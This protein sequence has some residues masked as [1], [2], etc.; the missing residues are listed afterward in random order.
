MKKEIFNYL[1]E[2]A[3]FDY[4]CEK[5]HNIMDSPVYKSSFSARAIMLYCGIIKALIHLR[6]NVGLKVNYNVF[7]EYLELTK[8]KDMMADKDIPDACRA[9]FSNYSRC[10]S[11]GTYN[12][13]DYTYYNHT[14]H[15][16]VMKHIKLQFT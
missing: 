11:D 4:I 2:N 1:L 6:D 8:I 9:N 3:D 14:F 16:D 15:D 5:T 12:D 7:Q 10:I 13:L